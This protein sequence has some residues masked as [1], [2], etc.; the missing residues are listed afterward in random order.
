M[1]SYFSFWKLQK[2]FSPRLIFCSK[3]QSNT[4]IN[5]KTTGI[6]I[7]SYHKSFRWMEWYL[8]NTR[9]MTIR[10][11]RAW[12]KTTFITCVKSRKPKI[13]KIV[14][15]LEYIKKRKGGSN[16]VNERGSTRKNTYQI[17]LRVTMLMLRTR[18]KTTF[19]TRMRAGKPK[20]RQICNDQRQK[21]KET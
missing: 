20:I 16:G 12:S 4:F 9:R 18:S 13:W 11:L 7:L 19:T 14:I 8:P 21:F 10:M 17:Q 6:K 1:L 3:N 2:T 15:G 5:P